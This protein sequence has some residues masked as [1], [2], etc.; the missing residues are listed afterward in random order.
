MGNNSHDIFDKIFKRIITLSSPTVINFINGIFEE[1]YPL[2]SELT[3]NWTESVDDKLKKTIADTIITINRTDSFHIEAQMYKDDN[4]IMLRMFDYGYNHSKKKPEDIYGDDGIRCGVRLIFP[5]QVVIY[6]D[7]S[8]HIPD[9]YIITLV[10]EGGKEFSYSVPTIKFQDEDMGEVIRKHM[11]ILLP[12]KL[13][14]IRERFKKEYD[15]Y[16]K[17]GNSVKLQNVVQELRDIYERDIIKTIEES[18]KN[19]EISRH[20]MEVLIKLTI[21]LFDHLYSKYSSLEEVDNMLYDQSLDLDIDRYMDRIEELEEELTQLTT[22]KEKAIA[23]KDN[24]IAEKDSTIAEKDSTIAEK[25]N[26]IAEK[27]ALIEQLQN[28][29][30]RY[31]S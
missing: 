7:S 28:E 13:L 18:F 1:D 25:D 14:K 22:E 15:S 31:K 21:R 3:Y 5:K 30:N 9:S 11:I 4:S 2:D 10:V 27:D 26:T 20:D 8:K 6:L 17:N 12:F 23:E 19:E 16:T 29:L 24:T